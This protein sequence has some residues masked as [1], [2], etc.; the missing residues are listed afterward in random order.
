MKA[1]FTPL[2]CIAVL[3]LSSCK[4]I[5][6]VPE[7]GNIV[8]SSGINDCSAGQTCEIDVPNGEDFSD[9]FTA[10]ANEGFVFTGWKRD[11]AFLCG[12]ISEPCALVGVPGSFT[13]QDIDTFLEPVFVADDR[14]IVQF[15][16]NGHYYEYIADAVDWQEAKDAAE[17]STYLGMD[18]YLVTIS[19]K[20]ENAFIA[21]LI[22]GRSGVW[23]AGKLDAESGIWSWAGGPEKKQA[24]WS[25]AADGEAVEGRYSNFWTENGEPD[26]LSSDDRAEYP[27]PDG[28]YEG[29]WRDSDGAASVPYIIEYGFQ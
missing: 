11:Q 5:Q 14:E 18:G 17:S 20:Q 9:T 29:R 22:A 16:G 6:I 12:G 7:G 28:E 1:V 4:I 21:E 27:D 2:V 23:I 13:D 15:E 3:V 26:N 25:G 8:S 10:V 24:F 19:S